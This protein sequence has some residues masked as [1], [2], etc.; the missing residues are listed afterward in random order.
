MSLAYGILLL[1][2]AVDVLGRINVFSL[3]IREI[4]LRTEEIPKRRAAALSLAT[5]GLMGLLVAAMVSFA[6]PPT[7]S[8][9]HSFF[10]V[11]ADPILT[12]TYS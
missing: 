6:Q 4:D 8:T 11:L 9:S 2:G 7:F 5:A 3:E 1:A 12:L 10:R